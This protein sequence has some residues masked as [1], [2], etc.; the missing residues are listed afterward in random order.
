M[1]RALA[2]WFGAQGCHALV[3]RAME[4]TSIAH[5][6]VEA[7]QIAA[8]ARESEA[9]I[10]PDAFAALGSLP[11][12]AVMSACASIIS[13]IVTLLGQLVGEDLAL[14]LVDDGWFEPGPQRPHEPGESEQG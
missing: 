7:I 10:A 13:E 4:R 9:V 8:S 14:R 2:R 5:P 12:E 11:T 3:V 6:A 1:Q